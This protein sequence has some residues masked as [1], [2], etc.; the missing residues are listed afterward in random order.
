MS[1]TT[2]HITQAHTQTE[3]ID[4]SYNC[5]KAVKDAKADARENIQLLNSVY[6]SLCILCTNV[7]SVDNLRKTIQFL[8]PVCGTLSNLCTILDS[9]DNLIETIIFYE[10]KEKSPP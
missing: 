1:R 2:Q 8:A 10:E 3:D 5:Y 6:D 7:N 9:L 4:L